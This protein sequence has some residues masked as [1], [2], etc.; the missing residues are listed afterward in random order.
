MAKTTSPVG[1]KKDVAPISGAASTPNDAGINTGTGLPPL[2]D[3]DDDIPD[4]T[5][6]VK[7]EDVNLTIST[8]AA[9]TP[10]DAVEVLQ[11][12]DL[13]ENLPRIK[14]EYPKDF[15]GER[16]F[17]NGA[18]VPVSPEVAVQFIESGIAKEV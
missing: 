3:D 10:N 2:S 16:F 14:I 8:G 13:H 1:D 12:R 4:L 9:S 18:I 5:S 7:V 6:N 11:E 15:K 17:E